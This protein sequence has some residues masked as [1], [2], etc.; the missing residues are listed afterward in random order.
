MLDNARQAEI[1]ARRVLVIAE[2]YGVLAAGSLY[3]TYAPDPHRLM[4]FAFAGIVI[5]FQ[6]VFLIIARDPRHYAALLPLCVFEKISF[7]VPAMAF[8]AR[9]QV[10]ETMA[11]AGA[12]DLLLA[13]LFIVAWRKIKLTA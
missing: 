5:V 10:G 1:F 6:G 3:F 8:A 2:I 4:Y 11:L 7:A 12:V 9:G 13:V